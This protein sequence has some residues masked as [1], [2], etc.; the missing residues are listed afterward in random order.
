MKCNNFEMPLRAAHNLKVVGSNPTPATRISSLIKRLNAA[1]RGGVCV[2]A[3]RGST[4]EARGKE[5]LRNQAYRGYHQ[6][7]L[8]SNSHLHLRCVHRCNRCFNLRIEV[9]F[10]IS[11]YPVQRRERSVP[12]SGRRSG[13]TS[14]STNQPLDGP[15][16]CFSGRGRRQRTATRRCVSSPG[17]PPLK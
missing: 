7:V 3:H 1:L 14:T 4:V 12:S 5:A 13:S 9:R 15:Q 16:A 6:K 11:G 10:D 8:Q 17:N 2:C